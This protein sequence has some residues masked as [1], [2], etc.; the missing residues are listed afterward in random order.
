MILVSRFLNFDFILCYMEFLNRS[1]ELEFFEEKLESDSSD[2]I[3]L[4]GRRRVGKT[5]LVKQVISSEDV[6]HLVSRET[7][8]DQIEEFKDSMAAKNPRAQEVENEWASVFRFASREFQ[9]VVIDEFPYLIETSE[10]ILKIL[11]K[12][13]DEHMKEEEFNLVITGSSIGMMESEVLGY[14]SPLYGRRTAEWLLEPFDYTEIEGFL[15]GYSRKDLIRTYAVLGGTPYYLQQF[16]QKK[17]IEQNILDNI[18]AQGNVLRQ[19][20]ERL[21]QQELRQPKNYFS[22]L[23]AIARGKTKYNEIQSATGIKQSS[24]SKYLKTLRNLNIIEKKIPVTASDKTKRGIY[25]IKDSY[26]SFWF[27]FVFPN[28]SMLQQNPEAVMKN[29]IT[30]EL[31]QYTSREFEEVCRKYVQ[32]K[33]EYDKVGSWWYQGQEI[34]VAAVNSNQDILLLGECKWTKEKVGMKTLEKLRDKQK[35]VQ[36]RNADREVKYILF[37]KN[38]FKQGLKGEDVQLVDVK[39]LFQQKNL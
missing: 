14:K 5:E 39:E 17:D 4:Y 2:F 21:L 20:A 8:K 33:A 11:Q 30:S 25:S 19:E 1:R 18:L 26:F 16:Q 9:T 6:Y 29:R 23:K 31:D 3:V 24:L 36:W 12:S 37:S 13:W 28:Q 35:S 7:E 15:P 22:C 27:R 38:G 34:D 32:M 10:E